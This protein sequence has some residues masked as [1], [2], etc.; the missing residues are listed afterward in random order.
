MVGFA[1]RQIEGR[2]LEV[3]EYG[4]GRREPGQ[5]VTLVLAGLFVVAAI[6]DTGPGVLDNAVHLGFGLV[7]FGLSRRPRGA[8]AFLIG[9]GVA[10]LLFW[11]FGTVI[12]ASLVPFHIHDAAVHLSLVASMI[13]LAVLSGGD[14][15]GVAEL[16][17]EWDEPDYDYDFDNDFD[18]ARPRYTR[19]RPPGRDD[20][21]TTRLASRTTEM[22]RR[23]V[24]L[25][26]RE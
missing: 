18:T 3:R 14:R 5:V 25:T 26:Y 2:V 15:V 16:E 13:G 6:L 8:R 21:R 22:G 11:Q 4:L 9:G 10:Y 7:G 19:N 20:R 17:Y 23:S 24:A 1:H 12:D